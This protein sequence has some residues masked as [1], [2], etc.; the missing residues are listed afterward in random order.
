MQGSIQEAVREVR[1]AR[2]YARLVANGS[3]NSAFDGFSTYHSNISDDAYVALLIDSEE[4]VSDTEATWEITSVGLMAGS[5]LRAPATI[6]C[7]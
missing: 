7:C 5:D 6:R 4:R 3:R 1:S 2:A